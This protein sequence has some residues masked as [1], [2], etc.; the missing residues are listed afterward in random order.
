MIPSWLHFFLDSET[1][2]EDI[3]LV[4]EGLPDLDLSE[5]PKTGGRNGKDK[6]EGEEVCDH[7]LNLIKV[8][9]CI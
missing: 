7:S 4:W 1:C 6:E 2:F 9:I 3:F 5:K 8:Y